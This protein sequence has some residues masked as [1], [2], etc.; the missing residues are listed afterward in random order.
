MLNPYLYFNGNAREAFDFY[1]A[2]FPQE[3]P[4]VMTFGEMPENPDYPVAE[5]AK[6]AIMHATLQ[7]GGSPLMLSDTFVGAPASPGGNVA[8]QLTLPDADSVRQ[9]WDKLKEG[10]TIDMPLEPTFWSPLFGSLTDK[11]GI[12]W[13][14]DVDAPY[15]AE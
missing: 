10:A 1:S 2:I 14:L 3:N 13:Q 12:I 9:A 5:D 4:Y 15:P 6:N 11:F 7:V 8:L